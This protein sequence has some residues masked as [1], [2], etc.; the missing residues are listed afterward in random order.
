[1]TMRP[2]SRCL[3]A[4]ALGAT[5]SGP[6]AACDDGGEN[7]SVPGLAVHLYGPSGASDPFAGVGWMR[8]VVTG[9]GLSQPVAHAVR[10]TPGGSGTLEG[11]PF[12]VAGQRRQ[13]L[14]EGW[15]D[16]GGQPGFVVSR[17][18][19]QDLQ[20]PEGAPVREVDVLFAR[21]NSFLPLISTS[22]QASQQLVVGRVGHAVTPTTREVV[23]TGG[24]TITSASSTWWNGLGFQTIGGT[25]EAIDLDTRELGSRT[26]MLVP[27]AWHTAVALSSGQVIIA[28]GYGADGAPT[29]SVEL[30]NPPGVLEGRAAQLPSLAVARAGHSATLIDE[31]ARLILFVGGD[32]Q[33]TW[34]LWDPVNGSGPYG[35]AKPLPDNLA[36]RHHQATTFFLPGRSEPAVLITGG[37]SAAFTHATAMLFDSVARALIPVS[38]ALPGG[39]RTQHSAIYVPARG[40]VYV[41]GG[42]SDVQRKT[43]LAAIDVFEVGNTSFKENNAGFRMRTPRGGHQAVLL[44]DNLVC[45]AG[46][47]GDEPP[48]SGLRPLGSLEVIHEFVDSASQSLR[49][50]VASSW[51][52]NGVG[53]VPFLPADRIGHR[54][55]ALDGMALVIGGASVEN[56]AAGFKMIK[57]LSLY[58]PQ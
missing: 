40:Y 50:E 38:M 15:S 28:G 16:A 30:Y 35:G 23:I 7:P 2:E 37:E 34:E 45:I 20:V 39:A 52:P 25:V 46:G 54:V 19:A 43:T 6:L 12:S 31:A 26:S 42:F 44:A 55:V 10:Y 47:L 29:N 48:G 4:L 8:F 27:R 3:L 13:L 21:V 1:M 11:I 58:N 56:S 22:T 36:R 53:Q 57:D 14:V 5:L 51:N 17:G 24:G 49:I 33:G 18:R 41:A 9:D 32:D